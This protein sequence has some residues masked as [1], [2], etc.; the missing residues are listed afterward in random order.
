MSDIEQSLIAYLRSKSDGKEVMTPAQLSE[1]IQ[2]SAKQQSVLR[3][4]KAFPIPHRDIGRK[5]FYSIYHVAEF[6]LSGSVNEISKTPEPAIKEIP[7]ARARRRKPVADMSHHFT[8]R[9]F[10]SHIKHEAEQLT[11]LA[12]IFE[13]Y[14]KRFSLKEELESK[15]APKKE[16]KRN[17][18]I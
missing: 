16:E 15:L 7:T 17:K 18:P 8:L 14:E 3:R 6:L 10:V 2:V 13:T 12:E 1:V 5:V 4:D 11:Y 9:M